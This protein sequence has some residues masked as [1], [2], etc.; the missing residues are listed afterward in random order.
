MKI[1]K[2]R[3]ENINSLKGVHEIDFTRNPLASAG[4]FAITGATGTGKTTILDVITLALFDRIPRVDD[5][6][7]KGLIERTGL[8]MTRNMNS[9]FAETSYQCKK[10]VFTTRW[11]ISRTRTGSLR[12][13]EMELYNSS[14]ELLDL[15]KTEVPDENVKNI[16]L[17]FNQF[18]KAIILAQGDFAAFLKAKGDERGL[19][20]EQITGSWIYRELGKAAFGRNKLFGQE[21][22][23]LLSREKD[24]RNR[25]MDNE[26][27]ESLLHELDE[28]E[29]KRKKYQERI[30]ALNDQ[31]KLKEEISKLASG[32]DEKLNRE[33]ELTSEINEFVRLNGE[34]LEKHRKLTPFSK[35]LWDWQALEKNLD[36]HAGKQRKTLQSLIECKNRDEEIRNEIIRLTGSTGEVQTALDEFEK[37]VLDI[38]RE[39][40]GKDALIEG[41]KK[42]IVKT[43]S[44]LKI[45]PDISRPDLM[46]ADVLRLLSEKEL[47]SAGLKSR[48]DTL[49]LESPEKGLGSLR[50]FREAAE[51]YRTDKIQLDNLSQWLEKDNIELNEAIKS[52]GELPGLISNAK[53]EKDRADLIQDNILKEK[54]IRELSASLEEHRR[55]LAEGEPCPLCGSTLHPYCE[56]SPSSPDELEEKIK[57]AADD[58]ERCRKNLYSLETRLK[59]NNDIKEK[60]SAEI[61]NLQKDILA[62]RGK[63]MSAIES[64][65]EEYRK[66]EPQTIL[67]TLRTRTAD[68]EMFI[69][70]TAALEKLHDLTLRLASLRKLKG[71]SD[72]LAM[73]RQTLFNGPDVSLVKGSLVKR[74]TE[75]NTSLNKL[76][77][78]KK[79][80]DQ[81]VEKEKTD[82][83][84]L[85]G[86]LRNELPDYPEPGK[87][88]NDLIPVQEYNALYSL[89]GRMNKGLVEIGVTISDMRI[90]LE[91]MKAADT[92]S[93]I[94]EMD[95]ELEVLAN[96][97][98]EESIRR[99]DF[100]TRKG[101]QTESLKEL[102]KVGAEIEMQRKSAEKWVLLNKYIGDADGKKFS[103]FAQQLTLHQLVKLANLRLR[104]LN[105]RYLLNI[106]E[107]DRD[108]SLCVIDT[109]MGDL[110]RSVKS[111]SGGES[112]LV[113]LSLA[114][115][116]SDLASR[117]ID[118]KSLFIDEGFGSLDRL[119]LDM[120]ID[121]LEKLQFETSKTIGVISHIDA[122]KER[123]ATQ[124]RLNRNGQGYSSMEII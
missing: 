19:L 42:E 91:E 101:V 48:I 60:K 102:G 92:A 93:K 82:L 23:L 119:T 26:A 107:E 58:C 11:S 73:K 67:D 109:H 29:K 108:D 120:T 46:E 74:F 86:E 68:L 51:R 36:T 57:E 104:M 44:G 54:R 10:G 18:V 112:F 113:S 12:E 40:A 16:G 70:E 121:T 30:L 61:A 110:K 50:S 38:E 62:A 28:S 55:R 79:E 32:L 34:R 43:C 39:K 105:D 89:E 77:E 14:G 9:C 6:I 66:L 115:A 35:K 24:L 96:Q 45:K 85:E 81:L 7:S 69:N 41:S 76:L 111:L 114:L 20:L 13:Y 27:F 1:L 116:L 2:L 63:C 78:D 53:E 3:F 97:M 5:K 52:L 84:S 33:K 106:P 47:S 4:L 17:N 98:R 72:D 59:Q 90:R 99:D 103:T 95:A 88:L 75:N 71:E 118:I 64:L 56:N 31:K 49:L 123:I 25:L 80:L 8:I 37:K 87:A 94:E 15:K 124:I 65:P 22:E 122:M 83:A 21:L 100:V 117:Q